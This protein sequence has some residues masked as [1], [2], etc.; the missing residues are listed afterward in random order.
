M[1]VLSED[2]AHLTEANVYSPMIL[3]RGVPRTFNGLR[4]LLTK[5]GRNKQAAMQQAAK[6]FWKGLGSAED[7]LQ[8][9]EKGPSADVPNMLTD[10][11]SW[12]F[13]DVVRYF[14]FLCS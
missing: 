12:A 14:T 2:P 13:A 1:K 7:L 3:P 11:K 4:Y 8:A 10:G 9:L 6:L 5:Y